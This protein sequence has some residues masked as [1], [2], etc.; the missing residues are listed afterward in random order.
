[1]HWTK[2]DIRRL[3]SALHCGVMQFCTGADTDEDR[4]QQEYIR[5][6]HRA[7]CVLDG[8]R[9][10]CAR[11]GDYA[12]KDAEHIDWLRYGD[13]SKV[14]DSATYRET[15]ARVCEAGSLKEHT[16]RARRWRKLLR[17]VE[18]YGLPE[19]F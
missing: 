13:A 5:K 2:A 11:W 17:K 6:T 4:E 3:E 15:L 16:A 18:T 12:E 7:A 9:W 19:D 14:Y 1:M 10:M 8:L